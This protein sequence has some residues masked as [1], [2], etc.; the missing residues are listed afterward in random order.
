MTERLRALTLVVMVGLV[1]GGCAVASA[2]A[3]AVAQTSGGFPDYVLEKDGTVVIDG[4][5]ATDCTS[6]ASFLEQGSFESGEI[7]PGAQR[8]LE[9][10]EEA[11]LLPSGGTSPGASSGVPEGAEKPSEA[12]VTDGEDGGLPDTGGPN[13]PALLLAVLGVLTMMGGLLARKVTTE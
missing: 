12:L 4:D 10:C 2:S 6:F 13:L 9:Q 11:G 3:P 5:G 1:L 8:V 7:S